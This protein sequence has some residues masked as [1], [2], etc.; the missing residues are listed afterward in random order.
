MIQEAC[1]K[2]RRQVRAY[3]TSSGSSSVVMEGSEYCTREFGNDSKGDGESL[4]QGRNMIKLC[5]KKENSD[6]DL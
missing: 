3:H 4:K 6:C 5:S 2:F 1:T